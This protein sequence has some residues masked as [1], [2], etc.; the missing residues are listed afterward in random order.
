[1]GRVSGKVAIV[2]GGARGIGEAIARL[3]V[4]EGAQVVITDVLEQEGAGVAAELGKNALFIRHDVRL[5]D[6]WRGVVDAAEQAF[7]PVSV[8]VNNA[9]IGSPLGS[10]VELISQ[11]TYRRIVDINQVGTFIGM[12]QVLPS[13]KTAGGGSIINM[14]SVSGLIGRRNSVAYTASKFAV[15][16]MTKV[17]AVEF[18]PYN[19][20]VNSVHPGTISSP[21]LYTREGELR[22]N[23][24]KIVEDLPAG[25]VGDAKEIAYMVLMLASDEVRF[26]TGAEFIVDGGMTCM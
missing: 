12:Q 19:V 21:M 18:G 1:M 11:E 13:M 10:D 5:E 23:P 24:R 8:L 14:S 20:R 2:T 4:E 17:A 15:R 7:G 25:R 26:A 9:G 16:G 6:Q 3:L 22:P